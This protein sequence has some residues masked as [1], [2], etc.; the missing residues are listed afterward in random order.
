MFASLG[1]LDRCEG[2][3]ERVTDSDNRA[4]ARRVK[5]AGQRKA[6]REGTGWD[7]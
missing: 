2:T 5:G 3:G 1:V 6:R 7:E 4:V